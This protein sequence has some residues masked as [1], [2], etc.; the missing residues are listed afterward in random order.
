MTSVVPSVVDGSAVVLG[1]VG[2]TG[3]GTEVTMGGGVGT[4]EEEERGCPGI[5]GVPVVGAA[6]GALSEVCVT[7]VATPD[8]SELGHGSHTVVIVLSTVTI[9]TGPPSLT[10]AVVVVGVAVACS[11]TV[12]SSVLT[13]P[14]PTTLWPS[15]GTLTT[16]GSAVKVVVLRVDVSQTLPA[17]S[18]ETSMTGSTT[19]VTV[20]RKH[21]ATTVGEESGGETVFRTIHHTEKCQSTN[22]S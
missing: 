12:D 14:P 18:H 13:T 22:T 17:G 6:R 1:S 15:Q 19:T 9:T 10:P 20:S 7:P 8:A 2:T 16:L 11:G 3:T 4:E 21:T 5:E